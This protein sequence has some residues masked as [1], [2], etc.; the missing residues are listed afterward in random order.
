MKQN[1][2]YPSYLTSIFIK[3]QLANTVGNKKAV[4]VRI[5]AGTQ[6]NQ[7]FQNKSYNIDLQ[8]FSQIISAIKSSLN[9]PEQGI[10]KYAATI[11]STALNRYPLSQSE[12]FIQSLITSITSSK[13]MNEIE[14]ISFCLSAILEAFH[15]NLE[16]PEN[17]QFVF[18]FS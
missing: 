12:Q 3:T 8:L 4:N 11:L 2:Q 6:L 9:D 7:L 13:D 10:R 5:L 17:K 15:G 14:G 18:N 1:P 16:S